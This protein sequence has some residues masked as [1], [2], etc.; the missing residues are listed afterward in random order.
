MGSPDFGDEFKSDAVAQ[1]SSEGI[2]SQ[3]CRAL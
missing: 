1:I 2:G 3:S